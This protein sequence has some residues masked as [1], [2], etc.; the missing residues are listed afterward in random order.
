MLGDH[1]LQVTSGPQKSQNLLLV[2]DP[3]QM[4]TCD[5]VLGRGV[6]LLVAIDGWFFGSIHRGIAY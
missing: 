4:P 1:L 3:Q 6:C 2:K 5:D